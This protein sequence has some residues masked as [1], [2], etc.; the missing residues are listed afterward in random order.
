M[1]SVETVL[2]GAHVSLGYMASDAPEYFPSGMHWRHEAIADVLRHVS[3]RPGWEF[4]AHRHPWGT[5]ILIDAVVLDAQRY[6]FDI[7]V[8]ENYRCGHT[9]YVG[10]RACVPPRLRTPA[11][12]FDW[13]LQRLI[14][15][16]RHEC[17]EFF[18]VVGAPWDSPHWKPQ[19]RH[20]YHVRR[21][22]AAGSSFR[23]PD[24]YSVPGWYVFKDLGDDAWGNPQWDVVMDNGQ[25]RHHNSYV[26]AHFHAQWRVVQDDLGKGLD[27]KNGKSEWV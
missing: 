11:Q 8:E 1:Q 15:V 12:F 16:E 21:L 2:N 26:E 9:T 18:Q 14:K 20:D 19:P 22:P 24:G 27:I 6:S 4:T 7:S 3:Y 10:V 23:F 25:P 5:Y 13:L 17:R